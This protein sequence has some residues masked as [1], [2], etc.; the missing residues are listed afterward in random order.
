MTMGLNTVR[1]MCDRNIYCIDKFTLNY[2]ADY[3]S[4]KNRNVSKAAK[5]IINLF[6]EKNPMLLEKKY[7]G[8]YNKDHKLMPSTEEEAA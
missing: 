3:W 5:S 2:L 4:Y 1:E 6:R 8:R 7:R